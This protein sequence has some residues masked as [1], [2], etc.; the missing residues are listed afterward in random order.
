[1]YVYI[2]VDV[3]MYIYAYIYMY[4]CLYMCVC[5]CVHVCVYKHGTITVIRTKCASRVHS[6][7]NFLFDNTISLK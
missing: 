1:M 2:Y 4:I 7:N 3:C 5:V 6:L